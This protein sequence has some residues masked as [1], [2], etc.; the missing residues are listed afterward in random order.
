MIIRQMAAEVDIPVA[1]NLDH[2]K[3]F[4]VIVKAIT[5]QFSSVMI[6]ASEQKFDE[7]IR[8]TSK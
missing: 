7:N 4:D 8:C 6:D 1:L 3:V 2:G 5:A